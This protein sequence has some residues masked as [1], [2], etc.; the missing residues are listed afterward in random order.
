M[1]LI[2]SKKNVLC[3]GGWFPK[4]SFAAIHFYYAVKHMDAVEAVLVLHLI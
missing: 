3:S 4:A 1:H 2:F